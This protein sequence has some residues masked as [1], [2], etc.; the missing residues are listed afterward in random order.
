MYK[1]FRKQMIECQK[2]G[3]MIEVGCAWCCRT[4]LVCKKYG[5]HCQSRACLEDRVDKE[6][7]EEK[8]PHINNKDY[9]KIEDASCGDRVKCTNCGSMGRLVVRKIDIYN[10]IFPEFPH[11]VWFDDIAKKYQC[12]YCTVK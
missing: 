11:S 1:S 2:N 6:C 5:I 9:I 3:T 4:I 10:L 12:W 7:P 8:W